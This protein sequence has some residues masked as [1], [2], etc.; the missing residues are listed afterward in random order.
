MSFHFTHCNQVSVLAQINDT[1][2]QL[3]ISP[4]SFFFQFRWEKY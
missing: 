2:L 1:N 4:A 3:L